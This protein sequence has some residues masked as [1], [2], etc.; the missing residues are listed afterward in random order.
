MTPPDYCN[1]SVPRPKIDKYET[2][3]EPTGQVDPDAGELLVQRQIIKIGPL[4]CRLCGQM[5]QGPEETSRVIRSKF[6]K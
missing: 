1:H 6:V 4:F 5:I 2:G 3:W